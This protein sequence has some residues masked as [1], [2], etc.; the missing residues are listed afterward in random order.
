MTVNSAA[1]HEPPRNNGP[2]GFMVVRGGKSAGVHVP[3]RFRRPWPYMDGEIGWVHVRP[4]TYMEGE[5]P[6]ADFGLRFILCVL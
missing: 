6:A 5:T 2:R 3:P 1:T 4:R